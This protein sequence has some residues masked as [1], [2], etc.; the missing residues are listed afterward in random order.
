MSLQVVCLPVTYLTYWLYLEVFYLSMH[1]AKLEHCVS[2]NQLPL[3]SRKIVVIL[4][5]KNYIP[6]ITDVSDVVE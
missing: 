1:T 5:V 6:R 2:K 4:Y 3:K